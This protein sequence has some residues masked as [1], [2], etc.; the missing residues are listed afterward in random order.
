M[1][2]SERGY[3]ILLPADQ[4]WRVSNIMKIP[5]SNLLE[6]L[7]GN[8]PLG[9]RMWRLPPYSANTWHRHVDQWELYVVLEGTG[10]MRVGEEI[11]TV[12]RHGA[13]LVEPKRLRQVFN[14]GPEEVLWLIVGAPREVATPS[15]VYPE[16]PKGLPPELSGRVWPPG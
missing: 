14:D 15:D 6:Q 10:R 3:S 7:D 11:L 4:K 9:G 5:N 8:A 2:G 16:D 1:S 13:V 12:P